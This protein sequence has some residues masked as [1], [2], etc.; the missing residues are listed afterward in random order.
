MG[1]FFYRR[2]VCE[3]IEDYGNVLRVYSKRTN[4]YEIEMKNLEIEK[5]EQRR[6]DIKRILEEN[7]E[8]ITKE[9]FSFAKEE[10]ANYGKNK[11]ETEDI[12]DISPIINDIINTYDLDYKETKEFCEFSNDLLKDVKKEAGLKEFSIK[13]DWNSFNNVPFKCSISM[14]W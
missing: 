9:I 13:N 8:L 4:D 12:T 5:K 3:N 1:N 6:D 10:Y 14:E 11:I 7:K 2:N